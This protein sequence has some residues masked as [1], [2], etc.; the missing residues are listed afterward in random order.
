MPI[1]L[2]ALRQD[3]PC[4]RYAG[5]PDRRKTIRFPLSLPLRCRVGKEHRWGEILNI[6]SVGALFT[7]DR[8]LLL[9]TP[10]ELYISW[11]VLLDEAV[12][13]NLIARGR[14]VRN[15]PGRAAL[16]FDR[17]EFR[18]CRSCLGV[19]TPRQVRVAT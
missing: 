5:A 9:D 19:E 7:T 15:E 17:Y 3:R 4:R 11:P 12:H 6:S 16:K 10:V 2:V 8:R 18:T 13:L 1:H 14:V